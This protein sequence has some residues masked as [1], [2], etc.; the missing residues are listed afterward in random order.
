MK[1]RTTNCI[2]LRHKICK[3]IHQNT[4]IQNQLENPES[5]ISVQAA[6]KEKLEKTLRSREY[7]R[8]LAS[9]ESSYRN[10]RETVDKL[11]VDDYV[12]FRASDKARDFRGP[13]KI[14]YP[15]YKTQVCMKVPT[16]CQRATK[17]FRNKRLN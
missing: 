16:G 17:V 11:G 8:K 14:T 3:I 2:K 1:N 15:N 12:D 5:Y 7:H 6:A 13:A 10:A 4:L 9:L